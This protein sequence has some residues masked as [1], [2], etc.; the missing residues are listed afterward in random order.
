MKLDGNNPTILSGYGGYGMNIKPSFC[1][2]FL[3]W[4]DL[5]GVFAIANIRGGGEYG[6]EW[7]RAGMLSRK[8][9]VFDDFIASAEYLIRGGYTCV[10]KLAIEGGSNGGL[11]M[12]AALTQR[13]ELFRAVVSH[14]GIYDMLGV[15]LQDNGAFK[16]TEFG[17]VK[18]PDHFTA[19]HAYSPYHRVVEGSH[20]PSVFLLSGENDGGLILPIQ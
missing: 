15:E 20:Y 14:A 2:P 13:P 1:M 9:S 18:D 8:Q 5:G 4:L 19:L 17:T 10:E 3:A 11:L 16:I 12:G 7:H 6:E